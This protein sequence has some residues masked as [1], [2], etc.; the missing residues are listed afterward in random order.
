MNDL[1]NMTRSEM[2]TLV[3]R[4]R[5]R[6]SQLEQDASDMNWKLNPDRMG[7]SFSEWE[8]NRRGDEF[9]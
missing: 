6:I 7:G 4:M 8:M 9:S 3:L 1:E 2:S 5:K